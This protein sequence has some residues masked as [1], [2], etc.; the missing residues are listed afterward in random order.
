M[1]QSHPRNPKNKKP[2]RGSPGTDLQKGENALSAAR[3]GTAKESLEKALAAFR[4][5]GDSS[6]EGQCLMK[7]G[8]TFEWMG[9]YPQARA[10]YEAGLKIFLHSG[11]R[12]NLAFLKGCLGNVAWA[13]GD[14][15]EAARFLDEALF[16]FRESGNLAR[17]A[18]V[19]DLMGNLQLALRED[20]Q[21][22][23]FYRTAFSMVEEKGENLENRAWNQFHLG[24][25]AFFRGDL[26]Q[27][28]ERFLEA[29]GFFG[30]LKDE[31]GQVATV[32]HLGE[33]AC[34]QKDY[35]E[36][37]RRFQKAIQKVALTQCKPL[38]ADALTGVAR[39]LKAQGDERKAVGLLMVALS[40]P[41]CRQQ[42]KDRMVALSVDLEARFSS[43]EMET[44]FR[45][46]KTVSMEEMAS[47]WVSSLSAKP[48]AK[49]GKI[50]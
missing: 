10:A 26:P 49:G 30:R 16:L 41:T 43:Q 46:A 29:L 39:L 21:A 1:T 9:E 25:L 23:L 32:I 17:Q 8:R 48:K 35:P 14:Y 34:D 18:W 33:V 47:A 28:T 13:T 38:L 24:T 2:N 19:H 20:R 40:H 44:G 37:E 5:S 15:T 11:A 36:A 45:W 12:E 4:K 42:T 27:A 22:E 31:L 6:G 50:D 3:L 7:L